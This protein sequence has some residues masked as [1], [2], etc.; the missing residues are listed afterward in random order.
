W[1]HGAAGGALA[2]CGIGQPEVFIAGVR[3]LVPMAEAVVLADH[4]PFKKSVINAVR[5]R[6]A[7]LGVARIVTTKKDRARM[8]S[9]PKAWKGLDVYV[10]P[11][12]I[13]LDDDGPRLL[14]WL[15]QEWKA[16][17]FRVPLR[18]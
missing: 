6:C 17:G 9:K 8:G 11:H 15:E 5:T 12:E 3:R 16:H 1:D 14:K 7:E 4:E 2:L 10:L 13:V 18:S